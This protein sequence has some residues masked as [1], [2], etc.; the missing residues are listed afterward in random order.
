MGYMG[1]TTLLYEFRQLHLDLGLP[2][3]AAERCIDISREFAAYAEE[4]GHAARTVTGFAMTEWNG[5]TVI[6]RGHAAVQLDNGNV[7]DWTARQFSINEDF[8]RVC[9]LDEWRADWPPL[10]T[11]LPPK[12]TP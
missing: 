8:P 9:T 6:L 11:K 1:M 7:V 5:E 10:P 3:G 12:E 4:W 2:E